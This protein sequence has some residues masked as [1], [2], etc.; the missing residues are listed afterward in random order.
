MNAEER[1]FWICGTGIAVV[2]VAM[3]IWKL[4]F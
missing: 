3:A 4:F 2:L 1:M